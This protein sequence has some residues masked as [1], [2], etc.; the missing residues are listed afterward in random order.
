M[1]RVANRRQGHE[2]QREHLRVE[3]AEQERQGH[4]ARQCLRVLHRQV[5]GQGRRQDEQRPG[6]AQAQVPLRKPQHQRDSAQHHPVRGGAG[7]AAAAL[8]GPRVHSRLRRLRDGEPPEPVPVARRQGAHLPHGAH[9]HHAR[10][11]AQH[12]APL[13][14]RQR[15]HQLHLPPPDRAHYR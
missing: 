3:C 11:G 15:A 13:D 4:Q 5:E 12:A 10:P 1:W 14:G 7:A 8:S 6:E 9:G 2:A